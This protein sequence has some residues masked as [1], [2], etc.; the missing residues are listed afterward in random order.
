MTTTNPP[1]EPFFHQEGALFVP[2]PSSQGPWNP[3]SLHGR[4]VAGLLGRCFETAYYDAQFQFTRLTVDLFR[5]PPMAPLQVE[6]RLIREGNRIRVA[7]GVVSSA[8]TEIA[9]GR[10]V[11]LRR[12]AEPEGTVWSPPDWD[13][14]DPEAVGPGGGSISAIWETRPIEGGDF[15]GTQQKRTWLRENRLLIAGEALTP[16]VRCAVAADYTNPFA[17]SGDHGLQFV[18]ADLT[19]Y[20][21]RLPVGEWLGFEVAS[22]HSAEGVAVGE[23]TMYDLTGPIGKSIVCGVANGRMNPPGA[24]AR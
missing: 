5:L 10:A 16:F 17:N 21:H 4:V 6:T 11:M 1:G 7:D 23:A 2:S 18:N 8:G 13:V 14:L 22:H 19:L 12:S 9:R 3:N 15:G 20:L 24:T